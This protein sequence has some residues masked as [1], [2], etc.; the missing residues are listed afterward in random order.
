MTFLAQILVNG[1]FVGGIYALIGLGFSLN[2]G[3]MNIINMAH[4]SFAM[5]GAYLTYSLYGQGLDPFLVMPVAFGIFFLTGY[6][7]QVLLIN[8]VLKENVFV[9]LLVTYGLDY[10]IINLALLFFPS[11]Y[12]MVSPSYAGMGVKF[13]GVTLPYTRMATL[14]V[15]TLLTF[16]LALYMAKTK[17]GRAIKATA[18]DRESANLV[19]I[20]V[21]TIHAITMA[22]SM[23]IAGVAGVMLSY[24]YSFDPLMGPALT[25]KAFVIA[26]I[27]FGRISWALIGGIIL[28]VV[29]AF[30]SI[31]LG[32][33]YPEIVSFLL[34][35]LIL[36]WQTSE[37]STRRVSL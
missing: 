30:T 34:L 24:T 4:G 17:V 37:R 10:I 25:M 27:G 28:G 23:G 32:S 19:G 6:L 33:G 21:H 11:G 18:M 35:V 15:A 3:V 16:F 12:L 20:P 36:L 1:I 9:S 22:I 2:W 29:E 13:L 14:A 26:I 5:L 31:T 7:M 8:R